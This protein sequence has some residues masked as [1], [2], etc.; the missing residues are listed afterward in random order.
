MHLYCIQYCKY[1]Y[2]YI[3]TVT[4]IF[5]QNSFHLARQTLHPFNSDSPYFH[6]YLPQLPSLPPSS[7]QPLVISILFSVSMNLFILGT[8]YNVCYFL[9]S[10]PKLFHIF[11]WRPCFLS[12]KSNSFT[13][14]YLRVDCSMSI[15]IVPSEPF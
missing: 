15:Y 14:I 13:R 9:K 11:A 7:L 8:S 10:L 5:P 4:T 2:I 3:A 1:I 12:L 6:P